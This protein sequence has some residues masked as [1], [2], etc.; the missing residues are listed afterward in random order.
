MDIYL[1]Q[2]LS[3]LSICFF[4]MLR[5]NYTNYIYD[6]TIH[7]ISEYNNN[8]RIHSCSLYNSNKISYA[9]INSYFII[10]FK[11]W[12]FGNNIMKNKQSYDLIKPILKERKR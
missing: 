5:I 9:S 3:I 4:C 1:H 6:K 12:Y 8:L 2:I 10:L 7:A 11:F